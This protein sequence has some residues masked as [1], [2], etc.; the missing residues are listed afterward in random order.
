MI[1]WLRKSPSSGAEP[2]LGR[3][4]TRGRHLLP[5]G[6]KNGSEHASYSSPHRGEVARQ[7]RVGEE[8]FSASNCAIWNDIRRALEGDKK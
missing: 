7:S 6:E 4:A 1:G 3:E 2:V 8:E 5:D